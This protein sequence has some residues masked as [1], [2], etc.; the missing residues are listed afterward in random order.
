MGNSKA[1][2]RGLD[3]YD[4]P[5]VDRIVTELEANDYKISVLVTAIVKS[6]P[7]RLRRGK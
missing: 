4:K 6:D 3:Y 7:F 5:T 1:L 2:G